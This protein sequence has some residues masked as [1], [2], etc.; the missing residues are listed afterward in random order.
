MIRLDKGTDCE[1]INIFMSSPTILLAIY[2]TTIGLILYLAFR[3]GFSGARW[4]RDRTSHRLLSYLFIA[5][6]LAVA[7]A[8]IA[9]IN[10]QLFVYGVTHGS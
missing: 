9:L 2:L 3:L 6:T 7:L 4:L 10:V 5:I 8:L 1:T